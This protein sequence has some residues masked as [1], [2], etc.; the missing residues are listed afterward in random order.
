MVIPEDRELRDAAKKCIEGEMR[1]MLITELLKKGLGFKEVED[2]VAKERV[3]MK[4]ESSVFK[5]A[6][7]GAYFGCQT[8]DDK[9]GSWNVVCLGSN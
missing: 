6:I 2:F 3:W 9:Y 8:T 1:V 7:C 4:T 5:T